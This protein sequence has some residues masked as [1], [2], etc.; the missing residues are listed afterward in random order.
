M[1][2]RILKRFMNELIGCWTLGLNLRSQA[3]NDLAIGLE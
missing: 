3:W 1:I 2:R